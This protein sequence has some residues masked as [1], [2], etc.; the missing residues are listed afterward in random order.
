MAN[1]I[2]DSFGSSAALT[3]TLGS[4]ASSTVGVGRQ[5]T[6]ID[7][8]TTKATRIQLWAS[9]TQGTSP[10]GNRGVYF[11]L[12]RGDG[13]RRA[14]GAGASDAA[15]TSRSAGII[16][17][18][19]IGVLANKSSPSTGDV[20]DGFFEFDNPGPEWGI[21]VIQDTAVALN[22]TDGNHVIRYFVADREVQ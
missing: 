15:L 21:W 14:E 16:N 19:L 1:K 18:P 20:L 13:T 22:A 17:A 6:L 11:Y 2:L 7:N 5:S 10:T 4:L 12:I 9:I 8:T 3:I